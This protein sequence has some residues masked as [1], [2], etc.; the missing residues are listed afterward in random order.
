MRY[1]YNHYIPQ[2]GCFLQ[3]LL[4]F[5]YAF[6]ERALGCVVLFVNALW[7]GYFSSDSGVIIAFARLCF[8]L[9]EFEVIIAHMA[10]AYCRFGW[11]EFIHMR[12][13]WCA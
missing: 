2:S 5:V 11:R 10:R 1:Y 9:C 3:M 12:T 7:E 4:L 6:C 8:F 13:S